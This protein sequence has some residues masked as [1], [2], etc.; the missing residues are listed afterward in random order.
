[1]NSINIMHQWFVHLFDQRKNKLG[2]VK[3]FECNK[4]LHEDSYK[5]ISTIYSHI[6]GKKQY[7]AFAGDPNNIEI[8]CPDCHNLYTMKPKEAIKQYNKYLKLKEQYGL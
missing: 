2:F 7:P 1:M 4:L 3:C 8:C 5:D 6:L